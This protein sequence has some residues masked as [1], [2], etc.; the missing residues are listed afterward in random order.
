MK[1]YSNCS[2]RLLP[3]N[4]FHFPYGSESPMIA[5]QQQISR[6][7]ILMATPWSKPAPAS[8]IFRVVVAELQ[9]ADYTVYVRW[10][11]NK[12]DSDTPDF[13]HGQYFTQKASAEAAFNGTRVE[14][15]REYPPQCGEFAHRPY[16]IPL[17]LL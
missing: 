4:F 17:H 16:R 12:T 5:Q 3:P 2:L 7:R 13:Y 15:A 14:L 6:C 9:E 1:S 10:Y 8:P 11:E